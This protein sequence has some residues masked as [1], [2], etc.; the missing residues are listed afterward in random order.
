MTEWIK[1]YGKVFGIY[2]ADQPF[3]VI[4]DT[5]LIRECF[6][7][8]TKVFQDRP[9]YSI[10]M[11][12]MVSTMPLLKG[13]RWRN[14]RAVFNACFTVSKVKDLS[15]IVDSSV[16]R[17]VQK[18][19]HV[20]QAG[21]CLDAFEASRAMVLDMLT[22]T[23]LAWEVD[24]QAKND[25]PSLNALRTV[26]READNTVFESA[27]AY[28][29]LSTILQ[30]VYPF[31][32]FCKAIGKVM[33]DTL[34]IINQ[35]RSGKQPR[36][37]DVLQHVIDT[38]TAMLAASAAKA[39]SARS[40]DDRILMC[41]LGTL[42]IAGFD[43]TSASLAFLLYLLA[44]HPEEQDKIEAE[45]AAKCRGK[46][47][48][49]ENEN[50]AIS[51]SPQGTEPQ[52][53]LKAAQKKNTDK[54]TNRKD[55][56]APD[57]VFD[58]GEAF[59]RINTGVDGHQPNRIVDA[60][61]EAELL[62]SNA[63]DSVTSELDEDVVMNLERLDMVV[64]EGLRL[65]PAIPVMIIR[66][67]SE[68]TTILG[69]FIP[70]GI[71]LVSP[72][73]HMHRDPEIWP[74]PERFLPDRFSAERRECLPSTYYP[75]GLGPRICVA[76]RLGMM[77]LKKTLYNIVKRYKLVL[78]DEVPDPLPVA[79]NNVVLNPAVPINIRLQ[80]RTAEPSH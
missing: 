6:I 65:Y 62:S 74:E 13:E 32:P 4:T 51:S 71:T 79:V 23:V 75:F 44:K 73:W 15:G 53:V 77:A 8:A 46:I 47:Q 19:D 38:Q 49:E 56:H 33:S 5:E 78:D 54:S 10:N 60:N 2:L 45:I 1:Q 42:L 55:F 12:P 50:L 24:C 76:H 69:R 20:C 35:R 34:D 28:P 67:C 39:T 63:P 18:M 3:M 61:A 41:N 31:T 57:C 58:A 16:D 48:M 17:F 40:I 21:K 22:R 36:K 80:P 25:D 66:Q 27:F 59:K 70:A 52:V 37:N 72:T 68:D 29:G 30:C 7:K 9:R 14:V 43:T 11:E 26:F 64:R